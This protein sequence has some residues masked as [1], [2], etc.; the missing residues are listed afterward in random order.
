MI[1]LLLLLQ[2]TQWNCELT[3]WKYISLFP[4]FSER[5]TLQKKTIWDLLGHHDITMRCYMISGGH[6]KYFPLR[7]L[8]E[9]FTDLPTSGTL[10]DY[11]HSFSWQLHD[12][13]I[14]YSQKLRVKLRSS[15]G[16]FNINENYCDWTLYKIFLLLIFMLLGQDMYISPHG[17]NR[18]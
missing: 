16:N 6:G 7:M 1:I 3:L 13:M 10:I 11:G 15:Q 14:K 17:V 5:E 9:H 4:L 12:L 18:M 2:W 8:S